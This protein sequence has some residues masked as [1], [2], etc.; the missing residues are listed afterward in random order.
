MG[1][2]DIL[3]FSLPAVNSQWEPFHF[4]LL[5]IF[6][7]KELFVAIKDGN[8]KE[9]IRFHSG[10][11]KRKKLLWK[12][13]CKQNIEVKE[14]SLF[15]EVKLFLLLACG[16]KSLLRDEIC[17]FSHSAAACNELSLARTGFFTPDVAGKGK[18]IN[19][20]QASQVFLLSPR[21]RRR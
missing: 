19:Y 20:D 21:R 2:T 15:V 3:L 5:R 1:T 10:E 9:S 6:Q 16:E 13:T 14:E 8:N 17:C 7:V 4:P 18:Q 11:R 12:W